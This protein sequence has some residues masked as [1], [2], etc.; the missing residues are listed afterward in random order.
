MPVTDE[1]IL[2]A[3]G[4]RNDQHSFRVALGAGER[5]ML[6]FLV[7]EYGKDSLLDLSGYS[8]ARLAVSQV[9]GDGAALVDVSPFP[10]WT[11]GR[12]EVPVGPDDVTGRI[13]EWRASLSA[14]A[15]DTG[16][17][18]ELGRG[19][20]DVAAAPGILS[21]PNPPFVL[22]VVVEVDGALTT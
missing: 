13:C 8:A 17:W 21:S 2:F 20:I 6:P 15:A 11:V 19:I 22:D 9:M 7:Y 1:I 4:P 5:R 12:V 10:S 3:L 16:G 18:V 14:Y